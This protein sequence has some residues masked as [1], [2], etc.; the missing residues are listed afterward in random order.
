MIKKV[1]IERAQSEPRKEKTIATLR[2]NDHEGRLNR[3]GRDI[4][5]LWKKVE[6]LTKENNKMV[7]V[8]RELLRHLNLEISI[9]DQ[10]K[11]KKNENNK[12]AI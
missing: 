9:E 12:R 7:S 10:V 5:I 8:I 11:L 3:Q 1:D 6:E 2:L 4:H